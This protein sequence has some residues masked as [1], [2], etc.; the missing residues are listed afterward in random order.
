MVGSNIRY[1]SIA[2]SRFANCDFKALLNQYRIQEA[3]RRMNDVEHY[4]RYTIEA[5]AKSVGVTSR[6]SFIQNFKK[7]T[8]LTPSAYLKF[9]REKAEAN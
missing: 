3:C 6:T 4:G 9:A 1:I 8:G 5:I 2:I 7:Q